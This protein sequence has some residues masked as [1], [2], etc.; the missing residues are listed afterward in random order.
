MRAASLP[1]PVPL[2]LL[3]SLA[4]CCAPCCPRPVPVA[5]PVVVAPKPTPPADPYEKHA[6]SVDFDV[7]LGGAPVGTGSFSASRAKAGDEATWEAAQSLS[8]T[9]SEGL[10]FSM[11]LTES[12]TRDLGLVHAEDRE[13]R[14]DGDRVGT[15]A[16][17]GTTIVRTRKQGEEAPVTTTH[18]AEGEISSV[19]PVAT[20]LRLKRLPKGPATYPIRIWDGKSGAVVARALDVKGPVRLEEASL[21]LHLDAVQANGAEEAAAFEMYVTPEDGSFLA[22]RLVEPAVWLVR[23]GLAVPKAAATVPDIKKPA[24]SARAV[25]VRFVMG[26]LVGDLDAISDSFDWEALAAEAAEKAGQPVPA[27]LVK[28]ITLEQLKPNLKSMKPEAAWAL[29]KGAIDKAEEKPEEGG[30]AFVR[31]GPPFQ[32]V[33]YTAKATGGVWR[34]VRMSPP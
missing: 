14:P 27:E 23:K 13:K 16:R 9:L 24:D 32:K 8:I 25:G 19:S 11:R 2:A 12:L 20:L 6:F 26:I 4:G 34:I 7:Y 1:L 33:A 31:L 21:G 29:V 28:T 22:A 5:A 30:A 18:V 15:L 10:Q 3:L 17:K